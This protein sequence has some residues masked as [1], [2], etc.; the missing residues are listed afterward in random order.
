MFATSRTKIGL[1]ASMLGAVSVVV[2][3]TNA[4]ADPSGAPSQTVPAARA[5]QWIHVD[6]QTGARTGAPAD[7]RAATAADPAFSTS[8]D[9]LVERPA[10]GGG[11]TVDL[12]G[13]FRS[14]VIATVGA[15]GKVDVDC[16]APGTAAARKE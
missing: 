13:R 3:A 5:G 7:A 6:P 12:Q 1:M 10:P 2:N 16:H 9:G 15:D 4:L 11:V 14:A 8:H